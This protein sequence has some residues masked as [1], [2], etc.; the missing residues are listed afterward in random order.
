MKIN[1]KILSIPPYVSTA[2]KNVVS[3]HLEEDNLLVIGLFNG[4]KIEIPN[5][6]IAVLNS[7]F[8]SHE[9]FLE[10]ETEAPSPSQTG[11][12]ST[13][14]ET[15]P[16][17]FPPGFPDDSALMSI[18]LRFGMDG[19]M[20]NLLQHNSEGSDSPDLPPEVLDKIANIS[21]AVGIENAENFPKPEPHCNCMHCQIMRKVHDETDAPFS[22]EEVEEEDVSDEDLRFREWDIEAKDGNLFEVINPLSAEEHYTVH[23]G[24]PVGCTCGNANCEHIRAV[25][26]S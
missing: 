24:N 17:L 26:N 8:A 2:W 6:D 1:H 11:S 23:L 4:S 19:N 18:P 21:K 22:S 20:G 3:L 12:Q 9:K 16:S 14:G 13:P 5:L 10:Q 25:L 7:V 15:P